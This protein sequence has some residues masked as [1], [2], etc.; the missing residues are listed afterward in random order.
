MNQ[1]KI[2]IRPQTTILSILKFL[3]YETWFALAEFVD[4]SLASYLLYEKELKEINGADF[5]LEVN[6]ETVSI[7]KFLEYETWFA[8]AE[9]VD[10]SL[11]SYLLYEKELK[12][13]N[14]ADFKLEVNIEISDVE[15]RIII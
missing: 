8:L 5:K 14:G 3:E 1:Q 11:A 10:N 6:I 7:L 9:F 12:E 15:N 13:I 2:N 4:N